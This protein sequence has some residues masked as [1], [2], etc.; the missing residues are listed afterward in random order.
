[1]N[2]VIK[3]K[4]LKVSD[5][6]KKLPRNESRSKEEAIEDYKKLRKQYLDS[7]KEQ[8][9]AANAFTKAR[10]TYYNVRDK[11]EALGIDLR[12]ERQ[13]LVDNEFIKVNDNI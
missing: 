2:K 11:V 9:D 13:N 6:L 10:E 7:K 8:R 5:T 1:M 12:K 3:N 4:L